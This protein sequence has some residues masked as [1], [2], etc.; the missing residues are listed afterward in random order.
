MFMRL[1]YLLKVNLFRFS[2]VTIGTGFVQ[3]LLPVNTM[4]SK[5][6]SMRT[7]D[8]PMNAKESIATIM[9]SSNK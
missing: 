1:L 5:Y 2:I 8:V 7:G 4:L 6:D 9:N 3:Q